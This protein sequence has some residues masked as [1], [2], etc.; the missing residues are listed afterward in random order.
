MGL[1]SPLLEEHG[2]SGDNY[3]TEHRHRLE[4]CANG[5]KLEFGRVPDSLFLQR[6]EV[7]FNAAL[8][9]KRLGLDLKEFHLN[10]LRVLGQTS[11]LGED[12]SGFR[13]PIV[14]N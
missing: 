10:K 5:D 7:S 13:L 6:W 14:V 3:S 12:L 11:E 4:K 8:F 9:E 1:T 2:H